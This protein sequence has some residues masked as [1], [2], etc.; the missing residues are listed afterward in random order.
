MKHICAFAATLLLSSPAFAD[1]S[2]R[3]VESAPKDRFVIQNG[4][5]ALSQ[6][7]VQIDL[8]ESTGALIFD[9]T[10]AGAGV[11]VFQ[12]VEVQL[13]A[14]SANPVT[15]GDQQLSFKINEFAAGTEVIISADLD[16]VLTDS[17]LGQIRVA[18]DELAGATVRMT[19][20]GQSQQAV[21]DAN[22]NTVS[23]PHTCSS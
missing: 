17:S 13:G 2:I 6:V 18:G 21:F 14:V 16:D 4:S 12:P 9:V 23:I 3:F 8:S 5:C 20:N 15:D 10:A 11:E 1:I 22:S 7:D 19:I